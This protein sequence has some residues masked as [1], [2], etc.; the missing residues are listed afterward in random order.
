MRK[1]VVAVCPPPRCSREVIRH[2]L[3]EIKRFLG[4][5]GVDRVTFRADFHARGAGDGG[6]RPRSCFW[7]YLGML[8]RPDGTVYPCCVRRGQP[9]GNLLESGLDEIWNN[10]FYR[11]SR[12]LFSGGEDL[13]YDP[14]MEKIPCLGCGLFR[15][16][17]GMA[18]PPPDRA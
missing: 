6:D 13:P 18:A 7:L 8:V 4:E 9:Y 3:P 12:A 17:R 16:R 14:D 10:R 5:C 1:Q 11:F 15:R 2:E